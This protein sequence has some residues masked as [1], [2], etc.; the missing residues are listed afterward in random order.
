MTT[1]HSSGNR[2]SRVAILPSIQSIRGSANRRLSSQSFG[3][4]RA[5]EVVPR[6]SNE[7]RPTRFPI[8]AQIEA[9]QTRVRRQLDE[10]TI[11]AGSITLQEGC[12]RNGYYTRTIDAPG[13]GCGCQPIKTECGVALLEQ[14]RA[15]ETIEQLRQIE[16]LWRCST[17]TMPLRS[18]QMRNIEI[19]E[20]AREVLVV[21]IRRIE[22]NKIGHQMARRDLFEAAKRVGFDHFGAGV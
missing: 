22:K 14:P 7:I 20:H 11:G 9:R 17:I 4:G 8:D 1:C 10:S 3:A 6:R 13:L 18:D 16:A 15:F 21:F 12:H 19:F 5:V 2:V